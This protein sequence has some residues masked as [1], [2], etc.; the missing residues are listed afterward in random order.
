MAEN[1]ALEEVSKHLVED[2]VDNS[3]WRVKENANMSYSLQGLNNY[4]KEEVS[5]Y[6]WMNYIYPDHVKKAHVDGRF[7]LH[8]SGSLS[9]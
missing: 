3:D 6:Y 2:Y 9:G 1:N 5:K 4:I 7:H 8:D